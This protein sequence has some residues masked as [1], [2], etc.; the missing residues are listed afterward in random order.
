M[1]QENTPGYTAYEYLNKYHQKEKEDLMGKLEEVYNVMKEDIK[2]SQKSMLITSTTH[3]QHTIR[4]V[5]E[6]VRRS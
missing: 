5:L 1:L 3:L 2:S 6:Y 4:K